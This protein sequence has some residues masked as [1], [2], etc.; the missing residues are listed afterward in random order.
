M[1][2][3]ES[4]VREGLDKAVNAAPVFAAA[5]LLF[6]VFELVIRKKRYQKMNLTEKFNKKVRDNLRILSWLGLRRG[7]SETLQEFGRRAV[8]ELGLSKKQPAFL[9]MYEAL[10]YG[11]KSVDEASLKEAG[12]EEKQLL[13]ILKEKK[14]KTYFY[15]RVRV[16][17]D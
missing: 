5:G 14:K 7:E 3:R 16:Y 13:A 15:Y 8:E 10:I 1:A 2:G 12:D 4:S 11:E 6:A 17:F 9:E